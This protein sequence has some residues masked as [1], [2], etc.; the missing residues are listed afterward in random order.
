MKSRD[1]AG[2]EQNR[3]GNEAA[4]RNEAEL[5]TTRVKSSNEL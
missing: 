3:L 4:G 2:K 5:G 1:R